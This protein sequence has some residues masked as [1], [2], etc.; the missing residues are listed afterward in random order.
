MP[1]LRQRLGA[2]FRKIEGVVESASAFQPGTAYW[3]HGKEVA[4][5]DDDQVVDIRLTRHAVRDRRAELRADPRVTLRGSGSDWIEV[6]FRTLADLEFVVLVFEAAVAAH[7]PL[8]GV[9]LSPPP[10]DADLERRR[11]FH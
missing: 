9:T 2:R 10:T 5:F 1:T 4:H 3:V 7:R 8:P 11:R 6:T